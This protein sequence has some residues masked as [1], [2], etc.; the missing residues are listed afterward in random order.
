MSDW[1]IVQEASNIRSD[2]PD[3]VSRDEFLAFYPQFGSAEIPSVVI[4][5]SLER[6]NAA[7]Q[8]SRWHSNWKIGVMLYTAH[9]VTMWAKSA[10]NAD[11]PRSTI[12]HKGDATGAMTSKSV[13]GVSVSYGS[14]SGDGDLAGFGNLRD[15]IFGQQLATMAKLVGHGMMVVR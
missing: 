2:G 14:T 10:A 3:S 7:I 12:A 1:S 6:A 9:M 8:E 13:G 4:D 5:M 15:T 11:D